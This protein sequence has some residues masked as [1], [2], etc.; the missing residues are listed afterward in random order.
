M[1]LLV[2]SHVLS[3]SCDKHKRKT[4]MWC[5][6][7]IIQEIQMRREFLMLRMAEDLELWRIVDNASGSK[8]FQAVLLGGNRWGRFK[9]WSTSSSIMLW[10]PVRD[11]KRRFG[12]AKEKQNSRIC[13]WWFRHEQTPSRCYANDSLHENLMLHVTIRRLLLM[14]LQQLQR[15]GL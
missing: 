2:D 1:H 13:F 7:I 3:A 8:P 11:K 4:L 5:R 15:N 12:I 9:T 14:L 6:G 10:S